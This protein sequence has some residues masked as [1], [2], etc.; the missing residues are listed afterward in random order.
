MTLDQM[1]QV[2]ESIPELLQDRNFISIYF[3]KAFEVVNS[4][5]ERTTGP[6]EP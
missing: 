1:D 6:K 5:L 3:N 4:D 2:K